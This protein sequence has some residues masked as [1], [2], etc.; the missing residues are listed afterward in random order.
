M[1][2]GLRGSLSPA[3]EEIL[4]RPIGPYQA[5][6]VYEGDCV[7]LIALLPEESIDV[8]V[9]S[10]PY[11]G[12]R[13]SPGT[14]T[15]DDPRDYLAFLVRVFTMVLPKRNPMPEG[16]CRRLHRQHESIFLLARRED[17]CFRRDRMN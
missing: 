13:L 3:M 2:I 8:L 9:T 15:E 7:D 17:H 12:Q 14:G 6:S 10:P 4:D 11:W 16:R 1:T 5:N